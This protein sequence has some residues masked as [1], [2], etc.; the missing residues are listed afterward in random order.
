M[1]KK[2]APEYPLLQEVAR[3]LLISAEWNYKRAA[4]P[5]AL[6]KLAASIDKDRSAGVMAVRELKAGKLE[7]IDGNHRLDAID[8][9]GW[10]IVKV[11]NFGPITKADAVLI[12]RRRNHQWFEDDEF[13]LAALIRDVVLPEYGTLEGL[14]DFMPDSAQDL[15]DM[16]ERAGTDWTY[17]PGVSPK[18]QQQ[19]FF[20][21]DA[22]LLALWKAWV[23][24]VHK[25]QPD[26]SPSAC[27]VALLKVSLKLFEAPAH[28]KQ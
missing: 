2:P 19:I 5:E 7:V 15:A 24:H 21:T 3:E 17:D 10:K 1:P 9:L 12:A 28:D 23:D 4:S 26:A 18:H 25:E 11:E 8:V 20:V 13:A 22:E 6:K 14:E 16:I 27:F